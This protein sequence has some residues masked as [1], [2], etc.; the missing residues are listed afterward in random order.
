MLSVCQ[1]LSRA[2]SIGAKFQQHSEAHF[3]D[4]AIILD[5]EAL[6]LCTAG[7]P[8]RS[9]CSFQLAF[10]L[11]ARYALLGGVENLNEAILLD[12]DILALRPPGHPDRSMSLNNLA[13]DLATR[14]NLLGGV[15]D[16]NEA[17]LLDRD[18]LALRPLGDP[19]RSESLNNLAVHLATRYDLFGGVEDLNEAI[20]LNRDALGLRL[21]GHPDRPSSL[22]NLAVDLTTRYNLLSGVEDLNEAILLDRDALGLRPPGHPDRSTSLNNLAD[23]LTIRHKLLGGVDDLNEAI[24]LNRDAL[25]LRPPGHPDRSMSLNNLADDLA[26]RYKLL[27][28]VEDLNEAILLNR[29]ALV[30]LPPGHPQRSEYLNNLADRLA[31]Q[32]NLLGGIEDLNKAILLCRDALTLRPPGH[33]HRLES[34][35]NL[36][37]HLATRYKLVGDYHTAPL[38]N[39]TYCCSI[40]FTQLHFP[41]DQERRFSLYTELTGVTRTVSS[42][43]LSTAKAWV[44]AAEDFHHPTTLLAY[45][46]TLRLLVRHLA[47]FPSLPQHLTVVRSL[48]SSLAADA[49]S[50]GLRYQSPSKAIELLEQG[51]GVFWNQLIRLRSPLDDVLQCGPAG[52]TLADEFTHLTSAIRSAFN[53]PGPD[54]HDR[55]CHFNLELQD[56]VSNIRQLPGLSHF[57]LPLRFPDLQDA[58]KGGPIIIVNASKYTCDALV[59]LA[60]KDPAHIPLSTTQVN[61]R[62][63]VSKMQALI[64]LAK[65]E[66]VTRDLGIILRELWDKIVSP[67]TKVLLQYVR[68]ES[69][70]WWCPTADF[71]FLPLHAAGPY[72]KG[73]ENLA[74]MFISSYTP[75]LS[76]LIRAR[77]RG[78]PNPEMR[79]Q[80]FVAIGQ[81][82]APKQSKLHSIG[83][84]L[85]SIGQCVDGLTTFTRI[86]GQEACISRVTD[87]L[88]RNEW[89]H[90][91]CHGLLDKKQPFESAFALYDGHLTIHRIVG[92]NFMNAEFAYLSACHT[93]VGDEESPDEVIHLASAMQFAGF[94]SVIGTMWQVDDKEANKVAPLFYQHMVDMSGRLD[95]TR[96]AFALWKTMGSLKSLK[97]GKVP[98][99]QRILY[100]HIGA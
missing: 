17:I 42:G 79:V 98:L 9:A 35:N 2:W 22:N 43:D 86:E 51:R 19:G 18:A 61:V 59:V 27:G 66:D 21:P 64:V 37:N 76:A 56:V 25:G 73:Q 91:A 99:D 68:R 77:R 23:D 94:R 74:D 78:L 14:Y 53:S 10:H 67:I 29:D 31:T 24:L 75:T 49:F 1:L 84:E 72:R 80:Q 65:K 38:E 88:S 83:I 11:S 85:A 52:R 58:A 32:Y 33:P 36:A 71:S 47:V 12:R 26:T 96:A 100:V 57:L 82:E 44:N 30:H 8:R 50:A 5:R 7:H 16:L 70:I 34:L 45:E 3:I 28:G 15:E 41:E 13:D 63:L 81:A 95:H 89:V 48:T 55:V 87:E 40:L 6:G 92:C 93:T 54:Q 20:L 39:F 46:T 62:E 97:S 69:R 90:L 4:E 60:D